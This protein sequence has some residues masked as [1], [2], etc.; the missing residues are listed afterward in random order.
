MAHYPTERKLA[1]EHLGFS[2]DAFHAMQMWPAMRR[3]NERRAG[4]SDPAAVTV[5]AKV[6]PDPLTAREREVAALV[7]RGMSNREIAEALVISE[8]TAEVHVKRILGK[9]DF[10]SRAQV[11][12][13]VTQR[14]MLPTQVDSRD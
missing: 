11:A 8:G 6:Q 1:F 13:W 10:K 5:R 4:H 7:A 2:I 12:T 3:A 14:A 9:L